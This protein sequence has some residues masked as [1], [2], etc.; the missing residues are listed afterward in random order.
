M[1][2]G[3]NK[4]ETLKGLRILDDEPF[5]D[6]ISYNIS[7]KTEALDSKSSIKPFLDFHFHKGVVVFEFPLHLFVVIG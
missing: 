4:I 7:N 5:S 1:S 6:S 3:Y 2:T